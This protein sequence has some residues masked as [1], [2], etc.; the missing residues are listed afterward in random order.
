MTTYT[1][2]GMNYFSLTCPVP[3]Q[4]HFPDQGFWENAHRMSETGLHAQK[5]GDNGIFCATCYTE[6]YRRGWQN[7][8]LSGLA[9]RQQ[10]YHRDS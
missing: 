7:L 10:L 8:F 9:S 6:L 4:I 2:R 1:I 5:H 3:L